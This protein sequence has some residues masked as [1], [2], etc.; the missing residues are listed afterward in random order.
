[1][2]VINLTNG[3][4]ISDDV[5]IAKSHRDRMVGLLKEKEAKALYLET[6]WGIH[7]FGMKFPIDCVVLDKDWKVSSIKENILPW[8]IFIWN[9]IFFRVFELPLGTV[10]ES[11]I[12]TGDIISIE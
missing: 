11:K 4:V 3:V 8:K 6:R 10:K 1:M 5:I 2:K 12:K 9:P 7:T